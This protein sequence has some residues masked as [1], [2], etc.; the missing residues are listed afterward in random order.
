MI[1]KSFKQIFWGYLALI[2]LPIIWTP[3][4]LGYEISLQFVGYIIILLGLGDLASKNEYFNRAQKLMYGL[5]IIS[6]F[7]ISKIPTSFDVNPSLF[8]TPFVLFLGVVALIMDLMF[9]Y[10]LLKGTGTISYEYDFI[11]LYERANKYWGYYWKLIVGLF[12]TILFAF[13]PTLFILLALSLAVLALVL[14]INILRLFWECSNSIK[15]D[16]PLNKEI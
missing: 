6:F 4:I 15:E 10:N 8:S 1:S 3:N 2:I 16:V 13:T 9:T 7:S 5:I 14:Q 12:A 11:S